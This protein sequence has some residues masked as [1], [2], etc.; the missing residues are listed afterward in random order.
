M[1]Y[2]DVKDQYKDPVCGMEVSR[3]SAIAESTYQGT[4]Y[5][6]CAGICKEEFEKD[7]EQYIR[8]R[9]SKRVKKGH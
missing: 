9:P 7:P 8:H 2:K 5:Y 4:T 3:I 1:K 6:F